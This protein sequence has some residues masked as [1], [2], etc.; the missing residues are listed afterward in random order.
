[1]NVA[2]W[3]VASV[4]ALVFLAAG[5]NKA[6][7]PKAKLVANPNLKWTEDFTEPQI[8]AIG[9]LEVLGAIGLILPPL[10]GVA[11]FLAPLAAVGLGLIMIGAAFVHLRRKEP[12]VIVINL[13]L[14]ALAVF[15][16]W[17]RFGSYSF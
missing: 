11:A 5:A 6:V 13:V 1:M 4:L 7:Q 2:L 10:V 15:V 9:A 16:A 14:L 17:G 8:K 3:I 12:Q